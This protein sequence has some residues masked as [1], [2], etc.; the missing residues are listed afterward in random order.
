MTICF[1][2]QEEEIKFKPIIAFDY[3]M[4][5]LLDTPLNEYKK[6]SVCC[7]F[8]LAAENKLEL[9]QTA[10]NVHLIRCCH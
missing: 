4:G 7:L 9:V 6:F 10:K 1:S 5:F 3:G 2:S 8:H